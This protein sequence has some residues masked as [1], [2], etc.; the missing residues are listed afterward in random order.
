[1]VV[2][3]P[4]A[5]SNHMPPEEGDWRARILCP[6]CEEYTYLD[7]GGE[8]SEEEVKYNQDER[9][10]PNVEKFREHLEWNH[11]ALPVPAIP[12]PAISN[13]GSSCR[14]M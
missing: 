14:V 11:T 4:L 9:G 7:Q 6:F 8:D 3:P 12:L 2:Y 1:M 13:S 10:F 5:I